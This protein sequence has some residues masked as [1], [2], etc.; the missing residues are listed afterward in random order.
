MNPAKCTFVALVIA[1][2]CPT[3]F[4]QSGVPAPDTRLEFYEFPAGTRLT[5]AAE[6]VMFHYNRE[7]FVLN[8]GAYELAVTPR[9]IATYAGSQLGPL[10]PSTRFYGQPQSAGGN[11]ATLVGP[12]LVLLANHT[13]PTPINAA[14]RAFVFGFQ[15]NEPFNGTSPSVFTFRPSNV[16]YGTRL[17]ANSPAHDWA[18]IEL[19]RDVPPARRPMVVN[20]TPSL[21][22]GDDAAILGFA[23]HIPFKGQFVT[24]AS[25]HP[26]SEMGWQTNFN[27][28]VR[29]GSSGSPLVGVRSGMV[30]GVVT[31]GDFPFVYDPE[32]PGWIDNFVPRLASA[33]FPVGAHKHIPPI[34]LGIK[35]A[36]DQVFEYYGPIGGPFGSEGKQIHLDCPLTSRPV[37]W[38]VTSLDPTRLGLVGPQYRTPRPVVEGDLTPGTSVD[39]LVQFLDFPSWT[40]EP[41]VH[42]ARIEITDL[43][44]DTSGRH[45][46]RFH[47]GINGFQLAPDDGIGL[48]SPGASPR[49]SKVYTLTNRHVV[50]QDILIEPDAPWILINGQPGPTTITLPASVSPSA[51][52]GAKVEV[53]FDAS[54]LNPGVYE[55]D[56][57]FRPTG[58]GF[59]PNP[60]LGAMH[61]R[62]RVD[63]GREVFTAIGPTVP[64]DIPGSAVRVVVVDEPIFVADLDVQVLARVA[65]ELRSLLTLEITSPSGTQALIFEEL[66]HAHYPFNHLLDDETNPGNHFPLS[67]FDGEP[68]MGVWTFTIVAEPADPANPSYGGFGHAELR[69]TPT[70]P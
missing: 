4:A 56:I 9:T 34:G 14:T 27:A 13:L 2:L 7:A 60:E 19:D 29:V 16:Y 55:G 12:R 24:V 41:G 65:G 47:V 63:V 44:Y 38:R 58:L 18:L 21:A 28:F 30:E 42:E 54:G 37:A 64:F 5:R 33:P 17:V 69:I 62:V 36:R 25:A 32:C 15:I 10:C 50:P 6:A 31:G 8:N 20:T 67:V 40:F 61:R 43:T 51:P 70:S 35:P 3:A 39:T 45:T 1:A 49:T 52:G 68:A 46:H 59:A 22:V 11:T 26:A 53:S 66:A 23:E 57:R 48:D